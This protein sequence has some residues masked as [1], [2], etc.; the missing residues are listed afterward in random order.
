MSDRV[1]RTRAVVGPWSDVGVDAQAGRVPSIAVVVPTYN[2]AENIPRLVE[3][4]EAVRAMLASP[5]EL[6][7]LDD[8]GGDATPEV[9]RSLAR[10]WVHLVER[11]G[12]RGLSAAVLEGFD[13]VDADVVVVMDADL[14]HPPE[15]IPELVLAVRGGADMAFGSRYVDGGSIDPSW[16]SFR[17]WNSRIATWLARGIVRMS[18][19]MSGFFA[20]ARGR[21]VDPAIRGAIDP[22]GYKVGLEIAA[23]IRAARITEVP[24][25][26]ADRAAGTSKL[27]LEAQWAY[28]VHVLR[29]HRFRRPWLAMAGG[30]GLA[31]LVLL[32]AFGVLRATGAWNGLGS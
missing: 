24:I 29:L 21:V 32:A 18:D 22:I 6:W 28:L 31:L 2:E 1:G 13:R 30:L 23:K 25:H 11:T 4:V 20:V 26:F 3:R 7:F 5:L 10:P 15:A 9:V 8:R 16:T 14:S 12:R 17:R 27:G 19:P